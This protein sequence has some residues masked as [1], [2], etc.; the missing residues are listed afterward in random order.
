[1]KLLYLACHEVL[2]YDELV[3][4]RAL[5]IEVFSPGAYLTPDQSTARLRPSLPGWTVNPDDFEAFQA[6]PAHGDR[7]DHL[8]R[9]FV[10][11]FDAV[12]VMHMPTRI[13]S[14]WDAMRHK[15][16]I[17]RTIGQSLPHQERAMQAYRSDGLRIVRYSPAERA[18]GHFS[19]EDALIR[20]Y[21]DPEEW[22]GWTG[23]RPY[24]VCV[25]QAL[26][27]RAV[28][29]NYQAL[30]AATRGLPCALYGPHNEAAG[31]LSWGCLPYDGLRAVLRRSRAC[32]FTG[33][34]PASYTLGFLEAW[35]TGIPIVAIGRRLFSQANPELGALY[36][37]PSLIEHGTS[38][39]VSDNC[40][41]LRGHLE[42][43]L[44]DW[45]LAR[46]VSEAGRAAARHY[47]DKAHAL[48]A[49][50]SFFN[51]FINI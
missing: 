24:V 21:K 15:T 39:F 20:F 43:L 44:G 5:G 28:E 2:E 37:V 35:M 8:T 51:M 14:N 4:F 26:P 18:L 25:A 22:G 40:D 12:L 36:E 19:G 50:R 41:D 46:A 27:Q 7:R 33:T 34:V 49:W 23:E 16:V 48:E 32:F 13:M 47:F 1:M 45:N 10:D 17:W 38:G 3:L 6:L 29:C 30:R 31:Q 9:A 11:R 42:R